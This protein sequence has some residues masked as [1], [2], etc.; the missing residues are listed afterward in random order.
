MRSARFPLGWL[1]AGSLACV[2]NGAVAGSW[3]GGG[4]PRSEIPQWSVPVGAALAAGV[5]LPTILILSRRAHTAMR[6]E[7]RFRAILDEALDGIMAVDGW[8]RIVAVSRRTEELF[9]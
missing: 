8:G 9:G 7:A 4:L 5:G 2:L 6:A 1:V 3:L